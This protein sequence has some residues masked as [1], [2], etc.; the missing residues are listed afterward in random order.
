[1]RSVEMEF[2]FG[3][4]FDRGTARRM[5][6]SSSMQSGRRSLSPADEIE[7]SWQI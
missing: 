3:E 2:H 5:S 4:E 7:L 1:M 6:G